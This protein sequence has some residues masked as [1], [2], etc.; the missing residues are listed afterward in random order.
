MNK[1][2]S[3]IAVDGS[4]QNVKSRSASKISASPFRMSSEWKNL[5]G[6]MKSEKVYI[7][8]YAYMRTE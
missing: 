8:I 7:Y 2:Y 4:R 3:Y 5:K 1:K 6:G